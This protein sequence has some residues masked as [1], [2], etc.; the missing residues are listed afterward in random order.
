MKPKS[1]RRVAV[2][3][4]AAGRPAGWAV[5]GLEGVVAAGAAG[6]GWAGPGGGLAVSD[7]QA[8][9]VAAIRTASPARARRVARVFMVCMA[10]TSL[11]SPR[12]SGAFIGRLGVAGPG[13]IGI[14]SYLWS[15]APHLWPGRSPAD[16]RPR[17]PGGATSRRAWPA[18]RRRGG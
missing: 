6:A 1:L 11:A 3:G 7:P 4:L 18:R 10:P 17:R 2:V 13:R 16:G 9:S 8:A 15:P 5:M 14:A 12:R